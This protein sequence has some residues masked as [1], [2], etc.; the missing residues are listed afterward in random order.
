MT[1]TNTHSSLPTKPNPCHCAGMHLPMT[2]PPLLCHH[3]DGPCLPFPAHC[4]CMC[5]LLCHCY[6]HE[7]THTCCQATIACANTHK[8]VSC[9]SVNACTE[10]TS[11]MPMNTL[12]LYR[13]YHSSLA[14]RP[15]GAHPPFPTPPHCIT[16]TAA[17]N[18]CTEAR[19]PW[20]TNLPA[21]PMSRHPDTLLL[22]MLLLLAHANKHRSCSVHPMKHFDRHHPSECC[23]QWSGNTMAPSGQRVPNLEIREQN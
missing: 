10:V 15:Q 20:T 18:T 22:L 13:H 8:Y 1:T 5:T 11:P 19:S 7:C 3:M 9:R 23:G 4:G 17:A 21:Q 16:T 12:P 6:Q 2:T 14:H